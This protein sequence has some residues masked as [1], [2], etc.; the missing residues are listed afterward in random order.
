MNS[1]RIACTLLRNN[2]QIYGFYL[3]VLVVTVAT[4]YNFVAIQYNDTFA[5]ITAR[6]QSATVAS[7]TCGFVLMCTVVFFMWHANGFFFK[8]R[9]KETGIYMLMGI[10]TSKIGRVFAIESVLL[11]MLSLVLGLAAGILFSKLFF[12]LLGKAM[13]LEAE[14]PFMISIKAIIQLVIVFGLIFVVLGFRNF[15]EVQKSQ[16]IQMIHATKA[17]PVVPKLN[18]TKGI[19]GVI[20]IAAGY[21]VASGFTHWISDLLSASMATLILVSFGTYFFFGSFLTIIFSRWVKAKHMVYKN[22]RLVSVSNIFFRLKSNYRSLAMTAILAAATVTAFSVSLAF[23]QYAKDHELIEAPYSISYE[24]SDPAVKVKVMEAIAAS[25]HQL[26]GWNAIHLVP[27]KVEYVSG[28]KVD[29]N[30]DAYMIGYSEL[31]KTLQF[32]QYP[33]CEKLLRRID[34]DKN[35]AVFIINA[36]TLASPIRVGGEEIRWNG[37]TYSLKQARQVPVTGNVAKFGKKNIYVVPDSA[38]EKARESGPEIT[39]NG[40]RI[41]GQ[42]NSEKLVQTLAGIVP[43]GKVNGYLKQ[44]AQ[45]YYT[46]G[47]FFFLGLIMSI[48]FVLATFSTIYF[49]ILSDAFSDQEQYAILKKIGMSKKEVERSVYLQVGIAFVLPVIV[50]IA[51]SVVA[52]DMLEKVLNVNFV[53]QMVLG[54]GLFVLVMIAFYVGISKNYT[55][56]VY[57]E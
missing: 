52:M 27:G 7:M 54:I 53:L 8:Q 5:Q 43:D 14:I 21:A 41:T 12:M 33:E 24:G 50:G 3:I 25:E 44:F 15:R 6:L 30:N 48:V 45:D 17:K 35:E 51:H 47:T 56:M 39:F 28:K 38:Y 42:E 26:L 10:S 2:L 23:K 9:Q 13:Y 31:E 34:P 32:L 16:L 55:K 36:N 49:K 22:V 20:L 1:F 40:I 37:T 19:L 46:L 29:F 4:Y 57:E 18:Y 11:G